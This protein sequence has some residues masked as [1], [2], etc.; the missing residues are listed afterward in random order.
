MEANMAHALGVRR[1]KVFGEGRCVPLD[2]NSKARILVL[3]RALSRRTEPGKAY[4]EVTAKFLAVLHALLYG[5]HNAHTGRCFPSYGTIA[6]KAGC[7]RTTVYEA[8]R[9]LERVGLLRWVNRL[10]RVRERCEDLF[11]KDGWR[12]RVVRTSNQYELVDPQPQKASEF[13][14]K[15]GTNTQILNLLSRSP[16][17]PKK[18]VDE[19]LS[20][21]LE[22]LGGAVRGAA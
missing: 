11:G 12:W 5:F 3:A 17:Q 6:D 22:R 16:E 2:R 7:S 1:S 9:A 21:A 20:R 13:N 18:T 19:G 8:I 4:G 10:L 14:S 15:T